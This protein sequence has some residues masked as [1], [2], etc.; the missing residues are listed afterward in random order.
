M[1]MTK[2][3]ATATTEIEAPPGVVWRTLTDPA[4]IKRFMFDTTVQTDWQPGSPIVWKGEY[5]GRAY[6]DKG[7][8][9]AVEPERRLQHTHFSALSGRDDVPENYHTLTYTLEP[10]GA[11]TLLTLTQDN[12]P[13]EEAADRAKA[14]WEQMLASLKT[15]AE[16][17]AEA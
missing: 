6:E 7:E 3:E 1:T 8:I 2:F 4:A 11:G 5:D 16:E 9:L 12:N 10:S 15:V 13:S 17:G 14:N